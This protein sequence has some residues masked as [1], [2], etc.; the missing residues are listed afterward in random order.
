MTT[1]SLLLQE[2]Q[3]EFGITGR[4]EGKGE[5]DAVAAGRSETAALGSRSTLWAALGICLLADRSA[6]A[7]S[8]PRFDIP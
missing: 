4:S 5:G 2:A 6:Y 7:G 3:P 1:F 8:P